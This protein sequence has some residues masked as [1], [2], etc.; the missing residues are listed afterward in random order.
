MDPVKIAK[1]R[2][3]SPSD[4]HQ[5]R[6]HKPVFKYVDAEH[7]ESIADGSTKIG[8]IWGFRRMEGIKGDSGENTIPFR[9]G[10]NDVLDADR[11]SDRALLKTMGLEAEGDF[12]FV[13]QGTAIN[14][15]G[16]DY[17]AC[18][19][20]KNPNSEQLRSEKRQAVFRIDDLRT[21]ANRVCEIFDVLGPCFIQEVT[22]RER[23]MTRFAE[24]VAVTSPVVKPKFFENE[25][26]VRVV[27]MVN[28]DTEMGAYPS[29]PI[30]PNDPILA[31]LITRIE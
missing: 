12:K 7:A 5:V 4:W 15:V 14:F 26:E 8:T 18:C 27:W 30:I 10:L 16:Q 29:L 24:G 25:Q 13:M 22:Y 28:H 17:Y 11:P 1:Y 2:W 3:G 9:F 21:W 23:V 19:F 6:W 31:C 20:A